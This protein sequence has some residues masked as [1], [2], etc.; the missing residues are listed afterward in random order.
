VIRS[1]ARSASAGPPVRA[2]SKGRRWSDD[3]DA[4]L[5]RLIAGREPPARI[6]R[7][8]QRTQDAIRGRAAQ[9]RLT[10]PS[11][12]RPWRRFSNPNRR[13]ETAGVV[14]ATEEQA[15]GDPASEGDA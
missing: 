3:D 12:L 15:T 7:I 6:A 14:P 1:K 11:P 5:R 9:L 2:G 4:Q 13:V 10:L 8:L